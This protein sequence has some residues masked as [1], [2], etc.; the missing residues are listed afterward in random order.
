[1]YIRD[2]V[3]PISEPTLVFTLILLIALA[4]PIALRHTKTPS[5]I[6]LI[7]IGMIIG[8]NTANIIGNNDIIEL[9]SKVG[10]LYIMFLAGLEIEFTEFNKNGSK[11][12][13]F[14]L[15]S[16]TFPFVMGY[17]ASSQLLD[18][19][20]SVSVLIGIL[21]ASNTLIAF[22]IVKKINISRTSAINIAISGT[23][24]ADTIVLIVLA[25]TSAVLMDE[26]SVFIKL[27]TFLIS[28]SIFSFTIFWGVPKISRWFFRY[29]PG[30]NHIHYLFILSILFISSFT[31]EIA[32]A[33]PIIG[34]FFAG[35]ALNRLIPRSSSLM[36]HIDL[37][38]NTLFIPVFLISIGML[39]NLV[40][41][42]ENYNTILIATLLIILAFSSKWIAAFLT[43]IIFNQSFTEM[44]TIFGLTTARAAATLAIALVGYEYGLMSIDVF[45]AI[46]LLILITSLI[47]SVLTEKYGRK[48]ALDEI[49]MNLDESHIESEKIL[50]P[51]SNPETM[52]KLTDL[53]IYIRSSNS[54]E[55]LYTVYVNSSSQI[56]DSFKGPF[57]T[58]LEQIQMHADTMGVRVQNLLRTDINV[59]QAIIKTS[60]ELLITK[61]ILG[62]S[63]RSP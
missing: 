57:K 40:S 37:V 47:S 52:S 39:V 6:G 12:I 9:F 38:G 2:F 27:G 49:E 21:L 61:I 25:F 60:K 26:S 48:L 50:V 18:L 42:F 33:E 62:W 20:P 5:I 44:N 23:V 34:A 15:T 59:S 11:S 14:G 4:V 35:L 7:I 19:K 56:H 54:T 31:A 41:I 30:D 3:L 63:G 36:N 45:N 22:P 58:T 13:F 51:I 16:F 32:G 28:F 10:L 29:I 1:M 55:P 46:I 53:A 8:P 17:F 24:I 43:K